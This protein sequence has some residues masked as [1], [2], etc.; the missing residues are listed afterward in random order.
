MVQQLMH[1]LL[2][3]RVK[4][5]NCARAEDGGPGSREVVAGEEREVL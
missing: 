1:H 4:E 3:T 5:E 2:K